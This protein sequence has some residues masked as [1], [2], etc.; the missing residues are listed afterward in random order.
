MHGLFTPL[1]PLTVRK[2]R[3]LRLRLCPAASSQLTCWL[4]RL[5]RS[6]LLGCTSFLLLLPPAAAF[7]GSI[8]LVPSSLL[9][10]LLPSARTTMLVSVSSSG[11]IL[12][13]T[14]LRSLGLAPLFNSTPLRHPL[15]LGAF[16]A[17]AV[18]AVTAASLDLLEAV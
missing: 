6:A 9:G 13:C 3:F 11:S 7:V 8:V 5:L 16:V 2:G 17:S 14:S 18:T 1:P 4:R 10:Q 15:P 12:R